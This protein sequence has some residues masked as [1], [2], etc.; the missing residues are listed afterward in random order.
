MSNHSLWGQAH[1]IVLV[2]NL[3]EVWLLHQDCKEPVKKNRR[4]SF[5]EQNLYENMTLEI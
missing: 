2:I 3:V 1:L 5:K 4:S